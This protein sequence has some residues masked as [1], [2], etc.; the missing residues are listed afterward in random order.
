MHCHFCF[1]LNPLSIIFNC[2]KSV[3][4]FQRNL[5][6]QVSVLLKHSELRIASLFFSPAITM[7]DLFSPQIIL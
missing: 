7:F 5:P 3:E 2:K 1:L 4:P 6:S